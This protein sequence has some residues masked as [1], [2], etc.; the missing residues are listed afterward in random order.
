MQH[1]DPDPKGLKAQRLMAVVLASALTSALLGGCG[2]QS[3]DTSDTSGGSVLPSAERRPAAADPLAVPLATPGAATDL[4][5]VVGCRGD[6]RF[7]GLANLSWSPADPNGSEQ[8]VQVT[9]FKDGF[10]T[11]QFESSKPLPPDQ[12]TLVFTDLSG[13][14]VHR[15][16]VV[17]LQ[18]ETA[19]PSET[20]RFTGPVCVGD[21]IAD[22]PIPEIQ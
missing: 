18:G 9:I 20:A 1:S 12:A 5:A 3:S 16:R 2:D 19:I 15:W 22:Q 13:Q 6:V 8:V 17:T 21:I 14:A 10:E 11:G 7:E 4:V